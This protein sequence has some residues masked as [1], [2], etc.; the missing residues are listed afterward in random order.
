MSNIKRYIGESVFS[1]LS[2]STLINT[3]TYGTY[4]VLPASPAMSIIPVFLSTIMA[5]RLLAGGVEH[6]EQQDDNMQAKVAIHSLTNCFCAVAVG[7]GAAI[8]IEPTIFDGL[9]QVMTTDVTGEIS[10]F[11]HTFADAVGGFIGYTGLRVV[12]KLSSPALRQ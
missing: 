5:Y 10:R 1:S 11:S 2:S 8:G 4:A 3:F 9:N 7:T 6:K 12:D